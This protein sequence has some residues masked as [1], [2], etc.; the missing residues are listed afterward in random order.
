MQSFL[1]GMIAMASAVAALLFLR[2]WRSAH[3]RLF[4]WFAGAFLLE[5]L[6][7]TFFVLRGARTEDEPIYF[8]FRLCFFVLIIIAIVEKNLSSR[9]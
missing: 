2:F 7:R 5:A 8:L 3:D 1:L 4:L 6:N 9:R